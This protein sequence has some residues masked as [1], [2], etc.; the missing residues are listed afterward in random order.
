MLNSYPFLKK[1]NLVVL[2][3]TANEDVNE[4]KM[5]IVYNKNGSIDY[6]QLDKGKPICTWHKCD[7]GYL[8]GPT[9]HDDPEDV[10]GWIDTLKHNDIDRIEL[11]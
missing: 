10:S 6:L 2:N 3:S 7:D 4:I 5:L 9:C 8:F 11:K 1:D